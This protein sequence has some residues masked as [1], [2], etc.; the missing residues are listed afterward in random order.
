MRAPVTLAAW[1]SNFEADPPVLFER[2]AD[3]TVVN[4]T[5]FI[6]VRGAKSGIRCH[7]FERDKATE[8][9]CAV[10]EVSLVWKYAGS[11]YCQRTHVRYG[12]T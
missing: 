6:D 8:F 12:A 7:H 5:F 11:R 2:Q 4:G 9:C 10:V 3:V 1:R